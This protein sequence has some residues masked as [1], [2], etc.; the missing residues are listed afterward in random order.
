MY[1][2]DCYGIQ[3]WKLNFI[4]G[5]GGVSPMVLQQIY[6]YC[7]I[8]KYKNIWIVI[9]EKSEKYYYRNHCTEFTT[10]LY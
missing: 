1:V 3:W 5:N 9:V 7:N 10:I 2:Y 4:N 6:N 8:Q